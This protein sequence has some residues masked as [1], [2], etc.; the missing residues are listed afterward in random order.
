KVMIG[1]QEDLSKPERYQYVIVMSPRT[2]KKEVEEAYDEF[3]AFIRGYKP[4]HE[5]DEYDAGFLGK[6]DWQKSEGAADFIEYEDFI[7]GTVY[8]AAD[9]TKFK[10]MSKQLER[11]R[12]WYWMRNGDNFNDKSKKPV[13][14]AEVYLQWQ[15]KCPT[16]NEHANE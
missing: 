9:I 6:I 8:D 2:E 10:T 7:K 4:K 11:T 15:D 14:Y 3:Q 1:E 13:P 16:H 5:F 12:E